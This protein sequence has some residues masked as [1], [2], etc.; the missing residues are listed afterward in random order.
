MRDARRQAIEL[1]PRR[2]EC[3]EAAGPSRC[4]DGESPRSNSFSRQCRIRFG[5][6]I[7]IGQTLSQRPQKVEAFGSSRVFSSPKIAGSSTCPIGPG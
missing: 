4:V 2:E 6:G 3:P 7:I 1:W 5:S